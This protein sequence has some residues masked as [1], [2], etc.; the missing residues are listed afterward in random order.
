MIGS[1]LLPTGIEYSE[2]SLEFALSALP[3]TALRDLQHAGTRSTVQ[4]LIGKRRQ[5]K[6]Y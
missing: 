1:I 4:K 6:K 3:W 2:Q 5:Q